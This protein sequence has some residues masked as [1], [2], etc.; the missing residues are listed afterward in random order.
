MVYIVLHV[1][2]IRFKDQKTHLLQEHVLHR[3]CPVSSA[4]GINLLVWL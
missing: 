3:P 2:Y 1:W 4:A